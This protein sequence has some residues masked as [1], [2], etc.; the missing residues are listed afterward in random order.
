ML[1]Q[2]VESRNHHAENARKNG[3]LATTLGVLVAVLLSGWTYSLFAKNFGMG[4]GEFELSSLVAPVAPSEDPPAPEPETKQPDR[5]QSASKDQK[6]TVIE[7]NVRMEDSLDNPPKIEDARA[8]KSSPLKPSEWNKYEEGT[9]NKYL[10]RES[11]R[12]ADGNGDGLKQKDASKTEETDKLPDVVLK[13]KPAPSPEANKP[14]L[15]QS[16]GVLNG[17]AINLV[18]PNYP[19][20][21]KAMGVKD[22]VQVQV[23]IDEKGS[24]VSAT[25]VS[26]N[27][28]LRAAAVQ[29]ARQTKFTPTL[30]TGQPVKV[31]GVI[32]YKFN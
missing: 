29:A 8:L 5:E 17:R 31:T 28:L 21:A 24:V 1:N 16:G 23:L 19:P 25:A 4:T 10:S 22:T 12:E 20:A 13:P 30:L 2:L 11:D 6:P 18:K 32:V 26:G 14:K 7:R 9:Q 27:P 15:P 3:F